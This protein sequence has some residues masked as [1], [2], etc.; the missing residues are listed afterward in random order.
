LACRF[1]F[2]FV[3]QRGK[4]PF[5]VFLVATDLE[6]QPFIMTAFQTLTACARCNRPIID[7]LNFP[8]VT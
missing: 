6:F 1:I 2:I 7:I 3:G 4:I 5:T 8:V